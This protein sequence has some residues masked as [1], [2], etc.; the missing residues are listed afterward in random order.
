MKGITK[1]KQFRKYLDY[2]EE[3][4]NNVEKAYE[5]FTIWCAEGYTKE[6]I[7]WLE[8]DVRDHD[9]SKFDAEEFQ[10]YRMKF[11]PT[12]EEKNYCEDVQNIVEE[13]FR[14]AWFH[15]YSNNAHHPEYWKKK[16]EKGHRFWKMMVVHMAIDLTAMSLKFGGKPSEY[17]ANNKGRFEIPEDGETILLNTLHTFEANVTFADPKPQK[18]KQRLNHE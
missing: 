5:F 2:L 9:L 8:G 12:E 15:H 14:E 18:S 3:H 16:G 10:A 4:L 11:F 1:I 6:E 13:N 17:Y 7:D